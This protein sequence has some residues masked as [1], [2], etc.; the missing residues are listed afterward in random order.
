MENDFYSYYLVDFSMGFCSKIL[1]GAIFNSIFNVSGIKCA[2]IGTNGI[3]YDNKQLYYGLTTPDPIDLHY[4]F[5]QLYNLGV[6]VVI[7]EASAHAIALNKLCGINAEAML[8]TNL[9]YEH[10]DFFENMQNYV[11]TKINYINNGGFKFIVANGDC[12]YAKLINSKLPLV[13]YGLQN[14]AQTFAVNINYSILGTDF[15]VNCF[16]EVFQVKSSLIGLYNVYNLLGCITIAY[17]FGLSNEQI[18]LGIKNLK[19]I[20]GRFNLYNL[21]LNNKVVIDF[22]HTPDGFYSVL[23]EIKKLRQ[24]KI[25]TIFGCVGYSDVIKRNQMGKIANKYSNEL[26]ITTDNINF[27]DFNK[28]ALDITKF[29][30]VPFSLI[31]DRKQ[32]IMQGVNKLTQNDTLVILGKG[33]ET[34]NLING[35]KVKHND[36]EALKQAVATNYNFF[37]K[38][39][40]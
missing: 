18:C 7:M 20:P 24:G 11:N 33:A 3:Y 2:I 13:F 28:V 25:I 9:T 21:D 16:D 32:A 38:E 39:N 35:E 19:H 30:T 8:Y 34:Y 36:F 40:A 15:F 27:Q 29:V 4:Y 5:K 26:I 12:E 22:A 31:P 23:N 14:P 10:V 6:K 17:L 37:I 1:P